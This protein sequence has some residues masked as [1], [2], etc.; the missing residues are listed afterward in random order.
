MEHEQVRFPL[1]PMTSSQL[2]FSYII[3]GCRRLS[4]CAHRSKVF[5]QFHLRQSPGSTHTGTLY[6]FWGQVVIR[7]NPCAWES[8][9]VPGVGTP[10][11]PIRETEDVRTASA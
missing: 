4:G 6:F 3:D 5:P 2:H 1:S 7:H 11:K 8:R 10:R 9:G